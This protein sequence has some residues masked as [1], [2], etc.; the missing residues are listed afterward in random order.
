MKQAVLFGGV[1][2]TDGVLS[3]LKTSTAAAPKK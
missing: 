2:I 3:R 1:D